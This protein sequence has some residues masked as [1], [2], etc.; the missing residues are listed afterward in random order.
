MNNNDNIERYSLPRRIWRVIYPVL[1]FLGMQF[2]V[3]I[4]ASVVIGIVYGM[5]EIVGGTGIL[6]SATLFDEL[7][8]IVTDYSM[9][10]LL[11][12]NIINLAVFIPMWLKTRKQQ[13]QYVNDRP[14]TIG[15]LIAGFFAGFN[16]VLVMLI[17]LTD[18]LRFFPSYEEHMG[19]VT[20]G[21]IIIQILSVGIAA[22][23]VEEL[24]F[25]GILLGRMK[26]LPVWASVLIQA[27]LFGVVHLNTF[28]IIYAFIVGVLFG[29]VY[30]KFRSIVMV[31][32]GHIAFNLIGVLVAEFVPEN[33]IWAV[34]VVCV[35]AV[36]VCAVFAIKRPRA[37]KTT[38]TGIGEWEP[39]ATGDGGPTPF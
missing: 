8:M 30:I 16:I 36:I 9:H 12:S 32:I 24:V 27:I 4:I 19:L 21:A 39:G 26:H 13:D 18:V 10:I 15:L 37:I 35:A 25:R 7:L 28:Q 31:I 6:D 20:G 22:P 17:G 29:L 23:V 11:G 33:F 3:V 5:R 2:V 1:I 38:M 34:V 14:V